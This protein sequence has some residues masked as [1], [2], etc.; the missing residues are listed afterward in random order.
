MKKKQFYIVEQDVL[1][2]VFLKVMEVKDLLQANKSMS[3]Q[4][5]SEHVGIS[6]SSFYKYKDSIM[7]FYEKGQGSIITIVVY[8]K[9]ELGKLS[10]VLNHIAY[11]G[12][13][14]LTLNQ[15]IPMNGIAMI[16]LCMQTMNMNI[17]IDELLMQ[18]GDINGVQ[19][20]KVLARE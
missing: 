17:E 10:D 1:P 5:A 6:R 13:N 20:V 14:I 9:D 11:V 4:E 8:L 7:P 15:M 12:G 2:E 3:V 16:N 19:S 18:L